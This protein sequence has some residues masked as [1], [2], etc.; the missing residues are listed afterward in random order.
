MLEHIFFNIWFF[1]IPIFGL[2]IPQKFGYLYTNICGI[3]T[4]RIQ[5]IEIWK[6][7]ATFR[8]GNEMILK[9]DEIKLNNEKY[10]SKK[11]QKIPKFGV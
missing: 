1:Y 4:V 2:F 6:P 7:T 3:Y 5:G 8:S 10:N 11:I 9:Q